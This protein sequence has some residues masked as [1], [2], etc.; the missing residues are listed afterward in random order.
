MSLRLRSSQTFGS[1]GLGSNGRQGGF[2]QAVGL[3]GK[4]RCCARS[5][6]TPSGLCGNRGGGRFYYRDGTADAVRPSRDTFSFYRALAPHGAHSQPSAHP[7]TTQRQHESQLLTDSASSFRLALHAGAG[8]A[9]EG[10]TGIADSVPPGWACQTESPSRKGTALAGRRVFVAACHGDM[11]VFRIPLPWQGG[12]SV[13]RL[14]ARGA[15]S[16]ISGSPL[17]LRVLV[18]LFPAKRNGGAVS[19]PITL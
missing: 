14:F 7:A 6:A 13:L 12:D 9:R 16:C 18:T 11:L 3:L 10:R 5:C 15:M 4:G 8:T 2:S 19:L 1:A 17:R